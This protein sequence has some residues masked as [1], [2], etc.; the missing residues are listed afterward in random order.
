M[1]LRIWLGSFKRNL[2]GIFRSS[3]SFYSPPFA[4]RSTFSLQRAD[5]VQPLIQWFRTASGPILEC[6]W[7]T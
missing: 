4:L 1:L 6:S 5:A 3:C 7:L 2:W